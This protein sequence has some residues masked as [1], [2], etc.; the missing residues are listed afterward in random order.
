MK[1]YNGMSG[2]N[3]R[4]KYPTFKPEEWV[5]C[6]QDSRNYLDTKRCDFVGYILKTG[7]FNSTVMFVKCFHKGTG[8]EDMLIDLNTKQPLKE[9]REVVM[10]NRDLELY[11]V[12]PEITSAAERAI[13]HQLQLQALDKGDKAEFLRLGAMI[14]NG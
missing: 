6:K 11:E 2:D 8:K 12:E 4:G 3:T 9:G 5:M 14:K 13:I 1:R 7:E 10:S